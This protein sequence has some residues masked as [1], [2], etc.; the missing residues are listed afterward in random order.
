M[1]HRITIL[2]L[3][4][5]ATSPAFAESIPII[6]KYTGMIILYDYPGSYE[7]FDSTITNKDTFNEF[8]SKIPKNKVTKMIPAPLNDDPLLKY[9]KIDFGKCMMLV[10]TD[11][12]MW[13]PPDIHR[14]EYDNKTITLKVKN[15]PRPTEIY[16]YAYGVGSY[17]AVIIKKVDFKSIVDDYEKSIGSA[18]MKDDGTI[19]LMLRA[20]DPSSGA[21]GDAM[22]TYPPSHAQ[23][24]MILKHLGRMKP[25]ETKQVPPWPN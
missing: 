11:D 13:E 3:L 24:Q 25:G 18:T 15:A 17:C 20:E 12:Y 14:I 23:Y 19:I 4:I 6:K 1:R 22:F 8:V 16:Q 7:A 5:F 10:V 2:L 9:P 21:M